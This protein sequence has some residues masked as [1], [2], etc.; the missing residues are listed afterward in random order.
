[1]NTNSGITSCCS[2]RITHLCTLPKVANGCHRRTMYF[3]NES[4]N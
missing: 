1:M 4:M 3:A 2:A